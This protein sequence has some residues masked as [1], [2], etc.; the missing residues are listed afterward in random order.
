MR[1]GG[2]VAQRA[3]RTC[4]AR[5]FI[6]SVPPREV[7]LVRLTDLSLSCGEAPRAGGPSGAPLAATNDRSAGRVCKRRDAVRLGRQKRLQPRARRT[8]RRQ[9][10]RE[11]RRHVLDGGQPQLRLAYC[12]KFR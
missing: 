9:L 7:W 4:G 2:V 1:W 5:S 3:S 12:Y 11:V 10:Q 6:E 8:A